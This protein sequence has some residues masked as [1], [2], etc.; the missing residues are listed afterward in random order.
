LR[1]NFKS[2]AGET[3]GFR[4]IGSEGIMTIG[5]GVTI[6][7]VPNE[8]EPGYTIGTF[9]K[10]TQDEFLKKYRQEYPLRPPTTALMSDAREEQFR[11][12]HGYSDHRD[13]HRNFIQAVR[14]RKPVVEDASF[15]YRAAAPA[16]ASNTSYFDSRVVNW[17]PDAM[18]EA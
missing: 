18:R 1:V 17:N 16:L 12:P 14:S 15:G 7:R 13:H 3:S 10:A 8:T 5:D 4:F 9:A 6:T 2:G 11:A